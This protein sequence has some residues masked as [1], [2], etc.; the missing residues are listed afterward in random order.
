MIKPFSP[1]LITSITL[2]GNM[3]F[4]EPDNPA[5]VEY[6]QKS[7]K[8]MKNQIINQIN[9]TK[10]G[11]TGPTGPT[12]PR[13]ANGPVGTLGAVGPTG[14]RGNTGTLGP[15][16]SRGASGTLGIMGVTGA[17]GPT[18]PQGANGPTGSTGASGSTGATGP[19]GTRGSTNLTTGPT[20]PDG[21]DGA[22]G[23]T[24]ATGT[25]GLTGATGPTG[26]S[27]IGL[28]PGGATNQVLMK[29][30]N[31]N[32]AMTWGIYPLSFSLGQSYLGGTIVWLDSTKTHGLVAAPT[33]AVFN[34]GT[35]QMYW[36]PSATS[37][38]TIGASADGFGAGAINSALILMTYTSQLVTNVIL[39]PGE[40]DP[41]LQNAALACMYYKTQNNIQ[42]TDCSSDTNCFSQWYLPS[43]FELAQLIAQNILPF[44]DYWTSTETPGGGAYAYLSGATDFLDANKQ[45]LL[46]AARC[47][48][49]F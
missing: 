6:V 27:A 29:S 19:N 9:N 16:G 33:D 40:I 42:V 8:V 45:G 44:G 23:P 24:G 3:T 25:A 12:G 10:N 22:T 2:Y 48:N 30:S 4:A 18:G 35:T 11:I 36:T 15:Q 26:A 39:A 21:T 38:F 47:V 1:I 34:G 20:G 13:G 31:T 37:A 46:A 41:T 14:Y 28:P 17:G 5:S 32:F 49:S 7:V 43:T